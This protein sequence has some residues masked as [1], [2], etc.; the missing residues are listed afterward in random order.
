MSE[1]KI[2]PIFNQ[3]APGVWDDMLRVR[4]AAMRHNYNVRLTEKDIAN[5]ISDF[6]TAWRR[7][8][9]NFAFA[10]YDGDKMVGCLNGD[11]Q[12]QIAYIRHLYVLPEY[13]GQ[14]LGAGL[15]RAAE[16]ATSVLAHQTDIISLGGA[17]KFYRH[18]GYNSPIGTNNYTKKLSAPKCATVPIFH[19]TPSF[20][21]G[22]DKLLCGMGKMVDRSRINHEHLPVFAGY[23]V[24]SALRAVCVSENGS[25][26]IRTNF[27]H[28]DD[29]MYRNMQRIMN[30]YLAHQ[31]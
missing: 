3:S 25:T 13:Q 23:D 24:D 27:S 28:P 10:A 18:M 31:K 5:A 1:I 19:C 14:Q 12:K 6:Q 9:Y 4:I 20:A 16:K 2:L 11:I 29:W 8:S 26:A 15:L 17:E 22:C 21:R 30:N 7:L